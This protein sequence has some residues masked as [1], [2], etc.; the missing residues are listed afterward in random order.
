MIKPSLIRGG[1]PSARESY[2]KLFALAWPAT[3]ESLFVAVIGFVDTIMVSGLGAEAISAVGITT[4]P[5]FLMMAAILSLNIGVTAIV[6]RRRGEGD[7]YGAIRSLKQAILISFCLSLLMSLTSILFARPLLKLAGAQPDFIDDGVAYFRIVMA[8]QFFA[9]IG[10]TMNAAQRGFGNTKISMRSN[11]AA[12]LVNILF[13]YLLINGI[14]IFPR[15]GVSGAA[16]ATSIGSVIAFIM[17]LCSL[18]RHVPGSLTILPSK[19]S[20]WRFDKRTVGSIVNVGSSALVEQLFLRFGFFTFALICANLGTMQFATHQICMNIV[21]IYFAFAEGIGIAATSLVGQNL[22]ALRPDLSMMYGNMCQRLAITISAVIAVF[23]VIFRHE[24]IMLFSPD[25]QIV[26]LGATI[27]LIISVM[28]MFQS[29]QSVTFGCLRGAGDSKY[30]AIIS[31]I[32]VGIIRPGLSYLLCYPLGLGLA[33]AWLGML[34]DQ[35]IRMV[36]SS[37]R[38]ASNKWSLIKL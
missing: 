9:C 6:A 12:N 5:K 15:L 7:I 10:M 25:P 32:S 27:V 20:S 26:S 14:W 4:Q 38:F 36:L 3:L 35:T 33:G 31:F 21:H 29:S 22:G 11:A 1:L 2:G 28:A 19:H 34:V 16:I 18:L 30:L 37:C 17:T 13:N 23:F 24:V 8:G